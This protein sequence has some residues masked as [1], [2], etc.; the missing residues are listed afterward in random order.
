MSSTD[1]QG[2]TNYETWA[3]NLHVSNDRNTH[4]LF[5]L[6]AKTCVDQDKKAWE[7]GDSYQLLIE[8]ALKIEDRSSDDFQDA[9]LLQLLNGALGA[10]NWREI[11][12][13]YID[14][15]KNNR[16]LEVQNG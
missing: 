6:V 12:E 2:W 9:L 8:S 16:E 4:K 11:A 3:V 14:A 1:Y 7:L 5:S 10:V 15:E 13:F